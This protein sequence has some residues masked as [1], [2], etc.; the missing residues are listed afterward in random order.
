MAQFFIGEDQIADGKIT[1]TG[2]DYNHIRNVLRMKEGEA[3]KAADPSGRV[4][5]CVL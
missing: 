1:V 2:G 4:Y 5:S 3:V